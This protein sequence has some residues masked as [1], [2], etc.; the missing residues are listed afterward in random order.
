[1]GID[2]FGDPIYRDTIVYVC[3]ICGRKTVIKENFCPKCGT[4]MQDRYNIM[5][6]G[7]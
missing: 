4:D 7:I 3:P 5:M 2:D 1:M 6:E